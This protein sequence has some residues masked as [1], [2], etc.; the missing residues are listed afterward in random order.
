[1][2]AKRCRSVL[3]RAMPF[4]DVSI[5]PVLVEGQ[6]TQFPAASGVYAMYDDAEVL[7]YI[8]ISRTVS[9]SIAKHSE[10][11][12]GQASAVKVDVLENA[13]KDVLTDAWKQWLQVCAD[14][15]DRQL[16]LFQLISRR[17]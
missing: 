10:Q 15:S 11:L 12:G 16:C 9:M 17:F 8:G 5:Q 6:P 3:T 1:V 14:P 13:T 7:Q 2:G 4:T